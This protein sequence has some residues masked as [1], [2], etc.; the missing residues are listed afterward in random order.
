MNKP[1]LVV[2]A[3]GMGS[4]YGGM[5]QIDPVGPCGQ[6]I[7]DY[8]LYDA[9]RAGFETVI[10]VIKHEIEEAFKAAI[11]DRVSRVMDVKY[12]FQQLDELPEGYTIQT[13]G[14]LEN[15]NTM[16]SQMMLLLILGF[17]LIYLVMVAQFQSLLSP[18]IV[19]LTVPLAFTGGLFGLVAAGEQLS[20]LSLLGFAVLMGT[21]VNNGI[22]FVDYVN[23]LR[24]GGLSKH[25][26]LVAAGRTRMR[27]IMMTAITTIFAM[28]PMVFSDAVGSSMQRGMA[29]V[30]VGGLLYATFMTL[31]VVPVMYDILYRRVP[32]E[33]D[34]GDESIDDDPGD[35]QAYL[36]ELQNARALAGAKPGVANAGSG[37]ST[38]TT[39]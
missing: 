11:G 33:V 20:M 7:V 39:S 19:I 9:R 16:L 36:E 1:V 22:V 23:Q 38:G 17:V 34:L 24:R 32:R 21:V 37:G 27:P 4:R 8:S 13:S 25:D 14:E 28:L 15:I 10:F 35:A 29:V 18:F 5:K 12:A 30:V 26:A 2:M 31:Y 6:V 3:A